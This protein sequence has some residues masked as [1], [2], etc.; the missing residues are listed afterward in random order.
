MKGTSTQWTGPGNSFELPV[1]VRQAIS[2]MDRRPWTRNPTRSELSCLLVGD[3]YTSTG[4]IWTG[5]SVASGRQAWFA[6]WLTRL[7]DLLVGVILT[8]ALTLVTPGGLSKYFQ[9]FD[10]HV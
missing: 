6:V 9:L 7:S 1:G 2:F 10:G 3:L 4:A 8:I 5:R